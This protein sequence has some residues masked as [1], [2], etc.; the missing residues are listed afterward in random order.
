MSKKLYPFVVLPSASSASAF[1]FKGAEIVA[2]PFSRLTFKPKILN[3]RLSD[4]SPSDAEALL[5]TDGETL[6][7]TDGETLFNT[8]A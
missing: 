3:W 5:N 7:N 1:L 6:L 2:R 8:G 4:Q